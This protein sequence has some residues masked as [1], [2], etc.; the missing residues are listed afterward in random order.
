MSVIGPNIV[1]PDINN[2]D[3]IPVGVG[4]RAGPIEHAGSV[5]VAGTRVR[6]SDGAAKLAV[7]KSSDSFT[8]DKQVLDYT[9]GPEVFTVEGADVI[10]S[11]S[12]H[13]FYFSSLTIV[14]T[15]HLRIAAFDIFTE[16]WVL[17]DG[18]GPSGTNLT[19]GGTSLT[20]L[21]TG[22]FQL[23]FT[24]H[25]GSTFVTKLVTWNSG[26]WGTPN[27]VISETSKSQATFMTITRDSSDKIWIPFWHSASIDS[28]SYITVTA[29]GVASAIVQLLDLTD[30][31]NFAGGPAEY[32]ESLDTV[33]FPFSAQY[34]PFSG[35]PNVFHLYE[36]SSASTT[37]SLTDVTVKSTASGVD[38]FV[39]PPG[40]FLSNGAQTVFSAFTIGLDNFASDEQLWKFQGSSLTTWSASP[41][42][43][44]DYNTNP[45][46]AGPSGV[47]GIEPDSCLAPAYLDSET[48]YGTLLTFFY[49][50]CPEIY[51]MKIGGLVPP[52]PGSGLSWAGVRR[53]A[54][55]IAPKS[56]TSI[57]I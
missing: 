6:Q 56:K 33:I 52:P 41:V 11:A 36:F 40:S 17:N 47:P 53:S 16:T 49:P 45:P 3:S 20:R 18:A 13:R 14:G 5:Y 35:K 37:P 32:L 57:G 43:D 23:L 31:Q 55:G 54:H 8:L 42:I 50:I 9:N 21:S 4:C 30:A 28:L 7:Y 22:A 2:F 46:E 12:D 27:T 44:W 24:D 10:Y 34:A 26:V 1:E 15:Q 51:Y 29:A 48:A 38:P 25:F 39:N 19:L